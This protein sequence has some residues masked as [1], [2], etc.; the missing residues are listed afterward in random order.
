MHNATQ[1]NVHICIICILHGYMQ[2]STF[3]DASHHHPYVFIFYCVCPQPPH[4]TR[5]QRTSIRAPSAYTFPYGTP[6]LSHSSHSRFVIMLP[7]RSEVLIWSKYERP[8][9][10]ICYQFRQTIKQKN[11]RKS[12]RSLTVYLHDII[13]SWRNRWRQS[14]NYASRFVVVMIETD[15][16]FSPAFLY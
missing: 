1:H 12:S 7:E 10:T 11:R 15:R 13:D 5:I 9:S 6:T 8:A 3:A 14:Q 2:N 16:T 4:S